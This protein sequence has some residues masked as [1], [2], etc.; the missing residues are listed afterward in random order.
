MKIAM[1]KADAALKKHPELE[2]ALLLQVHDELILEC[3]EKTAEKTA[4]LV[5]KTMESAVNLNV[6]LRASVEIGKRWGDFH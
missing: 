6:P 2:A 5:K 1:L 3:P 4:D